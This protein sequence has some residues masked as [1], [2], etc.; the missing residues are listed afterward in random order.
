[1]INA[2]SKETADL[3]NQYFR[4]YTE[5]VNELNLASWYPSSSF[6]DANISYMGALDNETK[7]A[8]QNNNLD[9]SEDEVPHYETSAGENASSESG[10]DKAA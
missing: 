5:P 4:T 10:S 6:Y 1:M 3:L 7:D 2:A 9:G 8:Q